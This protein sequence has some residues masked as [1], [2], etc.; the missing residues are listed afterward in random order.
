MNRAPAFAAFTFA[1]LLAGCAN[2]LA[3]PAED[4][5]A[6][7]DRQDFF[8]ARDNA[9]DALRSDPADA[10]ALEV[11]ARAQIAMGQGGDAMATLERLKSLPDAPIDLNLLLAEAHLQLEELEQAAGL[12][13]GDESAEAWRLRAL[14]AA[15]AGDERGTL[16]AFASGHDGTGDKLR[17]YV[18]EASY[19]LARGEADQAR[20]PVTLAQ[21]LAPDRV[22]TFFVTARLAQLDGNTELA[23]RAFMGILEATPLDRPALL[24]AIAEMGNMGRIDL[25][26]P[27]VER[28]AKAYPNDPEFIYLTARVK[29]EDQDW[30]GVRDILQQRESSLAQ[31][32]DS[33]GLY[34]EALLELGQVEQARAHLAPLYRREP[35]NLKVT[36]TFARVLIATGE[37]ARAREVIAPLAA[38][39]DALDEDRELAALA[40][41]G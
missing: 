9:Q 38:R 21:K 11:L 17:L 28:G 15:I 25:L 37:M 13:A 6:A 36:R 10:A 41:R 27:L 2:P 7:F 33:R 4:A 34:G 35:G 5:Q 3:D 31:H 22:E 16:R 1:C 20:D 30:A 32:P 12:L 19:H 26:R 39:D 24:G 8:G 29:A 14:A 23:T 40:A 18:A